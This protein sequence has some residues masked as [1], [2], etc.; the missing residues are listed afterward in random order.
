MFPTKGK[1]HVRPYTT[2]DKD[3]VYGLFCSVR[4]GE[5]EYSNLDE[6]QKKQFLDHQFKAMHHTY[7]TRFP[8]GEH[9][10]VV[11]RNKDVGRIYINEND[12][13]IRLLDIIIAPEQRNKGIGAD[14]LKMMMQRSNQINKVIRFYVWH[15]NFDAQRFYSRLGFVQ[16]RDDNSYLLFER[17]PNPKM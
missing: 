13:E 7:G 2:E 1:L 6:A 10:I 11:R 17:V 12:D 16:V 5:L 15:S 3:F 14:L 9:L 8:Q 4:A